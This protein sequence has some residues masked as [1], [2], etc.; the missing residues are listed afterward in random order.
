ME[1][2]I[3]DIQAQQQRQK[4]ESADTIEKRIEAQKKQE[5]LAFEEDDWKSFV[6]I[7][8]TGSVRKDDPDKNSCVKAILAILIIFA[9]IW[10][11]GLSGFILGAAV[12]ATV[13]SIISLIAEASIKSHET[14]RQFAEIMSWINPIQLLTDAIVTVVCELGSYNPND[15]KIQ[16][17]KMALQIAFNVISAIA[18]IVAGI[19]ASILT[20]GA[21]APAIAMAIA[22]IIT[23]IIQLVCAVLEYKQAEK[24]LELAEKRFVLNK[25]LAVIE[26]IKM[27]LEVISQDIDLLVEMFASKMSDVREEYEKASRILKEYNDTKRAIAQNIRS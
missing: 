1:V 18:I 2:F 14:K 5:N 12:T 21:A 19:A 6:G 24:E 4:T 3:S 23:G 22:G 27:N 16:K 13:C 15:E 10:F 7:D 8:R 26:Q 20:G 11:F 9:S 25:I 17:L